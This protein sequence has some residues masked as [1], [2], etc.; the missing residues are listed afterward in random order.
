[1]EGYQGHEDDGGGHCLRITQLEEEEDYDYL[2]DGSYGHDVLELE[3]VSQ[4]AHWDYYH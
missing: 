3:A 1:M 4:F 2:A